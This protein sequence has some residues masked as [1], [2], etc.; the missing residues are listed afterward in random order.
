M[1]FIF[2]LGSLPL[3]LWY[4]L[5]SYKCNS[6]SFFLFFNQNKL[7]CDSFQEMIQ[8]NPLFQVRHQTVCY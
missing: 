1:I 2:V 7:N 4:C 6:E 5:Y 8:V 3:F